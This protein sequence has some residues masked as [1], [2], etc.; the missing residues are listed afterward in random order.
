MR[1]RARV[2]RN[3]AEIVRQLRQIGASVMHTH[4]LG[5]GAPDFCIGFAGRNYLFE[6][7]AD[8]KK[9]L[10]DDEQAFHEAW[11]GSIHRV[12]TFEDIVRIINGKS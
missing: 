5:Q 10:T 7:K 8:A 11:R 1:Y 4:T 6:L 3:Q 9:K 12:D 2:D